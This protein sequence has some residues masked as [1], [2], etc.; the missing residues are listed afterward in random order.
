MAGD[1]LP[2]AVRHDAVDL[3]G[4][5]T[6]RAEIESDVDRLLRTYA[7]KRIYSLAVAAVPAEIEAALTPA[8]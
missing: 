1:E 2:A 8:L 3:D 6:V 5:D 4:L 7:A